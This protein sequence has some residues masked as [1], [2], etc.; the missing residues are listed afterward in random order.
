MDGADNRECHRGR[1]KKLKP[2]GIYELLGVALGCVR[3][4]YD[5]FCRM[6][7]EEFAAVYNAYTSQ[8]DTDYKDKWT[9]MRLLATITI[10]P[11]LGKNKKVTP[12]KLLPFPWEATPKRGAK[13]SSEMTTEQQRKRMKYLVEKLG[14]N[15]I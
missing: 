6:D 11:H 1:K 12:E 14:D 4:S 5:D 8:R 13:N 10:Q 2:P 3:L 7:F 9:R 15:I